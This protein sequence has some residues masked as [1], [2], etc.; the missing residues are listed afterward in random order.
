MYARDLMEDMFG[1][2]ILSYKS[3]NEMAAFLLGNT[4]DFIP[5]DLS[6]NDMVWNL[7]NNGYT[8]V[9]SYNNPGGHGH[10]ELGHP[11]EDGN[12]WM[13]I[14]AGAHV[15]KKSWLPKDK[16]I[17]TSFGSAQSLAKAYLYLGYINLAYEN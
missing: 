15:E 2:E 9:F 1:Y 10:I 13:T 16:S 8:V 5:L 12:L 6:K 7:V 17:R 11:D 14:G 3:A 4:S